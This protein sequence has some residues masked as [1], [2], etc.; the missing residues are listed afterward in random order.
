[1]VA[2]LKLLGIAASMRMVDN[3]EYMQR[4]RDRNYDV[5]VWFNM[6]QSVAPGQELRQFFG[7]ENADLPAGMNHVGIKSPVVDAIIEKVIYAP[8]RATKIAAARALDRVLNW[9]FYTVHL[10]YAPDY[11]IAYWDRFGRPEIQAKWNQDFLYFDTWW[12]DKEKDN[13]IREVRGVK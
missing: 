13:V 8:D 2:N 10:Y 7:S 5:L 1:M 4:I 9:S 6:A 11:M 12:I 3:T